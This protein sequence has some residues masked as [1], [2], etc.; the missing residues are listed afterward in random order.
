MEKVL[1]IYKLPYDDK[2]PVVNMDESPVQLIG[3][4]RTELPMKEGKEK[5]IDSEYVRNGVCDIFMAIEALAGK[6]LVKVTTTRTKKDWANFMK[7]IADSYPNAEKITLIMDNLNTHFTGSFYDVFK[8]E[9][10]KQLADRFNFVY[11]P[12]HG[13][14]LNI[15][16]IELNVLKSQCLKRRIPEFEI[17]KKE[18]DAWQESR[19]NK[20]AKV[21]WRFTNKEARI[22]LKR[23]YPSIN[24]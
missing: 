16:E 23:L 9:E 21:N 19:N 11:T 7:E 20:G 5:I 24:N 6:R 18:V 8:P 13:S 14:W 2:N 12:K 1:D 3:E 15:A 10:A 22:K 17:V 4:T